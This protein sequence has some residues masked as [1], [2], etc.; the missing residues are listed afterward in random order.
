MR[1]ADAS[2]RHDLVAKPLPH[3][4]LHR[5]AAVHEAQLGRLRAS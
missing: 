2:G 1:N 3:C 5:A 4:G